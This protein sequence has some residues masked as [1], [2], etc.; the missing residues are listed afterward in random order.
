MIWRTGKILKADLG[1]RRL[2]GERQT[3]Q[4]NIQQAAP[5]QEH[6]VKA[7]ASRRKGAACVFDTVRRIRND[8]GVEFADP[9]PVVVPVEVILTYPRVEL[10]QQVPLA[11]LARSRS[12]ERRRQFRILTVLGEI[13]E[14]NTDL[15]TDEV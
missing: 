5:G 10:T 14:S 1:A 15:D 8:H 2:D 13:R 6:G 4:L 11:I 9:F 3:L 12:L 7:A